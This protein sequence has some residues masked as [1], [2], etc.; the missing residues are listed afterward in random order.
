MVKCGSNY[1]KQRKGL[2]KMGVVLVNNIPKIIP[3]LKRQVAGRVNVV[4]QFFVGEAIRNSPY[5]TGFLRNHIGQ[6]LAATAERLEAEV[7]SLAPYSAPTDSG[8]RGTL[9]WTKAFLRA[10]E[11]FPRILMGKTEV[12]TVGPSIIGATLQ[13]YH[14]P[15]GSPRGGKP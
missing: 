13:E 3:E 11:M 6:T 5:D 7:R 4:A 1:Q 12:G 10:R 8:I 14:G 9:W 2:P 15:L